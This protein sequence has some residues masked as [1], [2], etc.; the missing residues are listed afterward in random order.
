MKI[1]REMESAE[2]FYKIDAEEPGRGY[3]DRFYN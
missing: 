1:V 2:C 3:F